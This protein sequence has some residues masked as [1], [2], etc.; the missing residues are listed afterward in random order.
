MGL[1]RREEL[2]ASE[3]VDRG[4][5]AKEGTGSFLYVALVIVS[6]ALAL[7]ISFRFRHRWDMSVLGQNSLSAQTSRVLG[8]LRE[9]VR[10][11][12]F[13]TSKHPQ[14]ED[15]SSLLDLYASASRHVR[16]EMVDPVARPAAIKALGLQ[17]QEQGRTR[18]AFMVAFRGDRRLVFR[19]ATE[20][21][22]TNAILEVG[23]DRKR[24]VGFVR[25]YGEADPVSKA[26]AGMFAAAE[27]LRAEYYET[28]DVYL[29]EPIPDDVTVLIIGGIRGAPAEADLNRLAAWIETGGRLLAL[30]EPEAGPGLDRVL[31]PYGIKL[32]GQRLVDPQENFNGRADFLRITEYS[33]HPV[34][35]SFGRNLPAILPTA[36]S[37]DH[38][39]PRDPTILHDGPMKSSRFAVGLAPDGS[40][41][42]G[43]F[44]VAA[45]AWKRLPG[46][47]RGIERELRI[48][49]VGDADFALNAYLPMAA[50]RNL[51]LN[52]VGWLS[53]S[54]GLV[55]VRKATLA[56]QILELRPSDRALL[57]AA[58][59]GGPLVVLLLG[60]AVWLRR[61]G[62]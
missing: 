39:E 29:S 47:T 60:V 62:L 14:R 48:F 43:P 23:S 56:G 52:A 28:R 12:A 42:Q 40:R 17:V 57:A 4:R 24:I 19:G 55:T 25:G 33:K 54:E 34:V 22:V 45:S 2:H 49:V 35:E 37:V 3:G 21:A 26:G 44:L 59:L 6:V 16:V 20:E 41:D 7:G 31:S 11:V 58:V 30:V 36:G 13:Y 51:F 50:N 8:G 15:A 18:D 1:R 32:L 27:A 10:I 53:R 38:V 9:D 46:S 5:R 61:R